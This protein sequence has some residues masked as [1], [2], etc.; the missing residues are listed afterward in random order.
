MPASWA[1]TI[2]FSGTAL[3]FLVGCARPRACTSD[4]VTRASHVVMGVAMLGMIWG[5]ELPVWLQ[6]TYFGV[7]TLW[8][9]GLAT[10]PHREEG[11]RDTH[12]ALMGAAM[13][14]MVVTMSIG[15]RAAL[16]V[17][18][19]V[20]AWYFVAAAVPFGYAALRRRTRAMDAVGHAAMSVGMG[21]LLLS[22]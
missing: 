7:V 19:A 13:V 4:R 9:A 1:L 10:V 21:V 12:H 2:L 11:L 15:H 3:W 17:V 8:F 5:T 22:M 16:A 14:W 18:T 20:M 6:V